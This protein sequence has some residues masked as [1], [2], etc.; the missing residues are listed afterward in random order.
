MT[1]LV[2]PPEE[3]VIDPVPLPSEADVDDNMDDRRREDEEASSLEHGTYEDDVAEQ[4]KPAAGSR[5]TSDEDENDDDDVTVIMLDPSTEGGDR[6]QQLNVF[7]WI[8]Q[9]G[10]PE[11][12]QRRRTILLQELRRVQRS[13]FIQFFVLCLFP[14]I[15][16]FVV[17]GAIFSEVEDCN[18][19]SSYCYMEP[20]TFMNAF[21]TRCICE[22][23]PVARTDP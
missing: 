5:G 2:L 9:S 8:E 11:I 15:L 20:R 14:T 16:L 4:E 7:E 19:E 23:L 10:A 17:I 22:S 6:D 3:A 13:S 21:T 1:I 18:S 12:E